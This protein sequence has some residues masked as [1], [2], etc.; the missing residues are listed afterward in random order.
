MVSVSCP[1]LLS[2]VFGGKRNI[3]SIDDSTNNI[4]KTLVKGSVEEVEAT[5]ESPN[6][7]LSV[8]Q[9]QHLDLPRDVRR[10]RN[11]LLVFCLGESQA[12]AFII[13]KEK[14]SMST[15]QEVIQD[16]KHSNSRVERLADSVEDLKNRLKQRYHDA[17]CV[18]TYKDLSCGCYNTERACL[19]CT[20]GP[21][22]TSDGL[23]ASLFR[24][25]KVVLSYLDVTKDSAL[26]IK[27]ITLIGWQIFTEPTLFQSVIIWLLIGSIAIPLFKSAVETT[28]SYPHAVLEASRSRPKG[29][30]LKALQAVVFCGYFFVP[31]LLIRNREKAKLRRKVLLEKSRDDYL[32]TGA[33]REEIQDELEGLEKYEEDVKEAYL[34]F[35]RNEAS[36]E[37]ILQMGLQLTMLLLS[38]ST[39]PTHAGLQ[40]VFGKDYSQQEGVLQ[41]TFGTGFEGVDLSEWLLIGSIIWSF[42]TSC[43]T[44]IC[45]KSAKKSH[46][47]RVA[48]KGALG[49]R[50]FLFSTSRIF[51]L[52]AFFGP[53]L[54]LM[55]CLAH[56]K[57][58]Q[59]A[60]DPELLEKVSTSLN[61]YWDPDTIQSL[62]K[63][64]SSSEFT[65]YTVISLR[66]AFFLLIG[67]TFLIG[68]LI[69]LVKRKISSD[70]KEASCASQ[71]QHVVEVFN[72][73]DA[74]SDWDDDS[75][76]GSHP[77]R[78]VQFFL[79]LF[80]RPLTPPAS[81][82]FV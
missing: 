46:S 72:F 38:M 4:L 61:A 7:S 74:F 28:L 1:P 65:D 57:A 40:G 79:T 56:W 14:M 25:G 44:F 26:V 49:L 64:L 15:A 21:K 60:L 30:K 50:A 3:S 2:R 10:G 22:P 75:G 37:I 41:T 69:L 8:T 17:K 47:M 5:V 66:E 27:L 58:Q 20:K 54:G 71:L 24:F 19:Q 53:F 43:K 29:R 80:K 23:G 70:F 36:F 16:Y 35:K 52:V 68:L 9:M 39:V 12:T 31:S 11:K 62:Y 34:I 6:F 13:L 51:A 42:K 59:K 48:A 32:S 76:K 78:K 67:S 82:P 55:D 77:L 18:V 45:I 81:P 63:T 73:P 33:V